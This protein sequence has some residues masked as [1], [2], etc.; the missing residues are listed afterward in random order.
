MT[1]TE[2]YRSFNGKLDCDHQ[3]GYILYSTNNDCIVY[4]GLSVWQDVNT[5]LVMFPARLLSAE[6]YSNAEKLGGIISDC[7]CGNIPD[8]RVFY[9]GKWWSGDRIRDIQRR[10]NDLRWQRHI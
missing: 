5:E 8:G 2:I 7:H 1:K 4:E 3:N 6:D 9:H 10:N